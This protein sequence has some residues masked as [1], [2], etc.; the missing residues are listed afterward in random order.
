[1]GAMSGSGFDLAALVPPLP[2]G[3]ERQPR[4]F[5][6]HLKTFVDVM[7]LVVEFGTQQ[8]VMRGVDCQAG[9]VSGGAKD[10]SQQ[11]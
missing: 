6:S 9:F 10:H 2:P 7:A 1:M 8:A 11:G 5:E 3:V 4:A